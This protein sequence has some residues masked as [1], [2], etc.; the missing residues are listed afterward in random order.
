MIKL[1]TKPCII[2]FIASALAIKMGH[3]MMPGS[4]FGT[5]YA[6]SAIYPATC[7]A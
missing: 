5:M 2:L 4:M 3:E 1:I 6:L 7:A